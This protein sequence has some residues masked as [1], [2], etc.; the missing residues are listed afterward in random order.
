MELDDFVLEGTYLLPELFARL[1]QLF[2]LVHELLEGLL[3]PRMQA[4]NLLLQFPIMLYLCL[5]FSA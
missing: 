1:L 5:C 2:L 4:L 3:L